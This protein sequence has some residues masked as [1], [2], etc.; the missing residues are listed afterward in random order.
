M[1]K[2]D[3]NY[4]EIGFKS[5]AEMRE[6][7]ARVERRMNMSD[8]EVDIELLKENQS[9]IDRGNI[10]FTALNEGARLESLDRVVRNQMLHDKKQAKKRA[11]DADIQGIIGGLAEQIETESKAD[12][13]REFNKQKEKADAELQKEIFEKHGVKTDKEQA[14]DDAFNN[15]LKD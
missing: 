7:I 2:Y 1:T 15:M 5:D 10:N 3:W 4:E 11:R 14:I 13:E 9:T 8:L 6:S 12:A